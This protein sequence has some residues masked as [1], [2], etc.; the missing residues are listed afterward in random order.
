MNSKNVDVRSLRNDLVK[1]AMI[2]VVSRVLTYFVQQ[3]NPVSGVD[4]S[5]LFDPE[6]TYS[7]V[8]TLVGFV[9][10]HL[11]VNHYLNPPPYAPL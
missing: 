4:L 5:K 7:L 6:W 10:Y 8:F 11:L 1:N 9:L 3:R 2:I